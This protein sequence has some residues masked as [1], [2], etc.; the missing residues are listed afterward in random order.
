MNDDAKI[1]LDE[2]E[3]AVFL[4]NYIESDD[5]YIDTLL[6]L[7]GNDIA[8]GKTGKTIVEF[9]N[10][11]RTRVPNAFESKIDEW[12][13]ETACNLLETLKYKS[14]DNVD[15][16]E[17]KV[18]ET[19]KKL[20]TSLS[21]LQVNI[22]KNET[23]FKREL[24]K[25]A[26]GKVLHLLIPEL[27]VAWDNPISEHYGVGNNKNE[28]SEEYIKFLKKMKCLVLS[29]RSLR[30]DEEKF[31]SEQLIHIREKHK[32]VIKN[33]TENQN[34]LKTENNKYVEFLRS[35]RK[36]IAKFVDEYNWIAFTKKVD[37]PPAWYPNKQS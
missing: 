14:I 26:A 30:E 32:K 2:F 27:F 31:L 5:V 15:F 20:Y 24:G 3:W 37:L 4:Y 8:D 6:K 10:K 23:P 36:T 28:T 19:I 21:K 33:E 16:E 34:I 17:D 11:W 22:K 25:V 7:E 9:L 35:K 12:Y 13:N 1:S 29:L 18:E